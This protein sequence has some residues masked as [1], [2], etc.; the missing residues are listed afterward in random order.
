MNT[1][2]RV[3]PYLIPYVGPVLGAIDAAK[4]LA[5]AFPVLAKDINGI[6]TNDNDNTSFGKAR[7]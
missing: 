2:A 3:A 4:G 5:T 1:A 7:R 6:I